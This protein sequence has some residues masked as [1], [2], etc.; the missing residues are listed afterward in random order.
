MTDDYLGDVIGE[1]YSRKH[2]DK[3]KKELVC[4]LVIYIPCKLYTNNPLF[5]HHLLDYYSRKHLALYLHS[6][7]SKN[8]ASVTEKFC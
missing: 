6:F 4:D 8:S 5:T 2:F 1:T 3:E 7:A